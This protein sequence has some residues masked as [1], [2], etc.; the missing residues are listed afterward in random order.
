MEIMKM[1]T[2][3]KV[4]KL[5]QANGGNV[6]TDILKKVFPIGKDDERKPIFPNLPDPIIAENSNK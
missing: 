3:M 6:L 5:E 1:D 4:N 2:E